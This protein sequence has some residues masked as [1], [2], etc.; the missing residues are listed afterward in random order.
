MPKDR[1]GTKP[2]RPGVVSVV[3]LNYR[4]A[5]ETVECLRNLSVLDWPTDLLEVICV[6]NASGDGSAER[7][8]AE[9]PQ[10]RL[11]ESPTNTGFAGGCNFGASHASGEFLALINNDARPDQIGRAVQQECGPIRAGS[12]PLS[13]C[14]GG[15]QGSPVWQVRSWTG[16]AR[17]STM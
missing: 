1:S 5:A 14:S 15:N 6:D 12:G 11:V 17:G 16:R 13:R 4:S 3:T 7:I 10:V 9:L 2:L 8:R